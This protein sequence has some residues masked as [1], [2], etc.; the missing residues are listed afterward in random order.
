MCVN[1]KRDLRGKG[2]VLLNQRHFP[3]VALLFLLSHH[4]ARHTS[5]I[6]TKKPKININVSLHPE[7]LLLLHSHF[8]RDNQK[9]TNLP[10]PT[11]HQQNGTFNQN[12]RKNDRRHASPNPTLFHPSQRLLLCRGPH[13]STQSFR[14]QEVINQPLLTRPL[15]RPTTISTPIK[16]RLTTQLLLWKPEMIDTT[17]W[18]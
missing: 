11:K 6:A 8:A 10:K 14:Y 18:T 16:T 1:C 17:S 5:V 3:F 2:A 4:P 15:S 13:Q 7:R 12:H 9:H